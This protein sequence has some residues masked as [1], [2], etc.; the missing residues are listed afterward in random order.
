MGFWWSMALNHSFGDAT[1][2]RERVWWPGDADGVR[3]WLARLY[4]DW[5][6]AIDA[7]DPA[8]LE[9]HRLTRWPFR[10]RPF[11]DVVAWANLELMKNASEIGYARFLY[12]VNLPVPGSGSPT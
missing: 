6:A 1:L 8:E 4:R 10:D 11:A 3:E 9:S 2:A 5:R 12:A 7:L